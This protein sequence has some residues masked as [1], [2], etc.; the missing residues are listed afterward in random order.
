M[1]RVQSIVLGK[2]KVMYRPASTFEQTRTRLIQ[3]GLRVHETAH[4][5]VT[6]LP[7]T[8]SVL[9]VHQFS[10]DEIDNNIGHYLVQELTPP[11]F[12]ISDQDFRA[13]FIGVVTSLSP[14]TPVEAWNRFSLNTLHRLRVT[15]DETLASSPA[16][17][18]DSIT[19][20]AQVY[21]RLLSLKL[22]DSLLDVGC[23]CAF[24]PLLVA[25]REKE[26]RERIV[27]IDN[28]REAITLSANLAA[29][30]G[31]NHLE[32]LQSDVTSAAFSELGTFDTVTAIH[33]LEHI[34]EEKLS[35]VF[36]NLLKVTDQRL[37][38]AVPYEQEATIAYGHRVVFTPEK[39]D[40]WGN[41]CVEYLQGKGSYWCE[42]VM[43]GM[44]IVDK[45][46]L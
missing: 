41:R 33:L 27:G 21:R 29:C 10:P 7:D 28:R 17:E 32:F 6:Q 37:I 40:S 30:M 5:L 35:L 9:I 20:F 12:M 15:M 24:W 45:N 23:A 43:G 19:S 13:A 46:G 8:Q 31:I 34:P 18:I 16:Y 11:G 42:E 14:R 1:A 39:L 36:K 38:I 25:E 22:G 26:S 44:L 3:Q 2:F 4:F